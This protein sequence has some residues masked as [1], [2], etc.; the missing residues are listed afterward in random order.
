MSAYEMVTKA[1]AEFEDWV[2]AQPDDVQ[3]LDLVDQIKLYSMQQSASRT[4]R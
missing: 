4:E 3:D 2:A 1:W